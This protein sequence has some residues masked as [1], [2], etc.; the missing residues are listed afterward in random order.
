MYAGLLA[1]SGCPY[2]TGAPPATKTSVSTPSTGAV[3]SLMCPSDW[4]APSDVPLVTG[5]PA[6]QSRAALKILHTEFARDPGIRDRFLRE[7]YVANKVEHHG[8]VAIQDDDVTES[9]EPFLGME[10]LEGET[11]QQRWKRKHRT[12]PNCDISATLSRLSR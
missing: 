12:S 9:D 2:S 7:G 11:A 6:V 8:R 1:N 3:I 10:L 4:I 5:S